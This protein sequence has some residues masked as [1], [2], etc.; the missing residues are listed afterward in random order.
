MKRAHEVEALL[1][2]PRTA[3]VVV[4]T[5]EAAPAHEA[6][7]LAESLQDRKMTVGAI[8]ANRVL[9][10]RL[11][12]D[13]RAPKPPTISPNARGPTPTV[14]WLPQSLQRREMIPTSST[15]CCIRWRR[16]STTWRWWR[17][18]RRIDAPNSLRWLRRRSPSRGCRV[19]STTCAASVGWR[20]TS[21]GSRIRQTHR[22]D[23]ARRPLPRPL[24]A[25]SERHRS[26]PSPDGGVGVP[27]RPLL[28]GPAPPCAFRRRSMDDHRSG[29]SGDEP[30]DVPDRLRRHLGVAGGRVDERGGRDRARS[31]KG[32]SR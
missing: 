8:V 31:S 16:G 18:V 32:T 9:P 28:L 1:V 17:H 10:T 23:V 30:D 19:T 24:V 27:R 26:P 12:S 6:R 15:G 2:D 5:L 13:R 14:T 29:P 4:S 22:D 20:V 3:F 21:A 25:R 11:A 7:F